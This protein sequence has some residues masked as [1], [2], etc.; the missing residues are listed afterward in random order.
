MFYFSIVIID[1]RTG[2]NDT[3]DSKVLA[4]LV[5][6]KIAKNISREIR[7]GV[8]NGNFTLNINGTSFFP[9][10]QSLNISEPIRSC[11]KGQAYRDGICGKQR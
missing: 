1:K 2:E 7:K 11:N 10:A 6:I 8:E 3:K 9:D 5:G 4:G